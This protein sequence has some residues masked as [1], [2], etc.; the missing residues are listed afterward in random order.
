MNIKKYR[1]KSIKE[2]IEMVKQDLGPD[3]VILATNRIEDTEEIEMLAATDLPGVKADTNVSLP[4]EQAGGKNISVNGQDNSNGTSRSMPNG[5][6]AGGDYAFNTDTPSKFAGFSPDS[7][8]N[9]KNVPDSG[10]LSNV[11]S[12]LSELKNQIHSFGKQVSDLSSLIQCSEA[13]NFPPLFNK[14]VASGIQ[15]DTASIITNL[16]NSKLNL[17]PSMDKSTGTSSSE[18]SI[19]SLLSSL[20][21]SSPISLKPI[22]D[23]LSVEPASGKSNGKSASGGEKTSSPSQS[24]TKRNVPYLI[25]F[26]GPT[27][28]G[29]TTTIAKIASNFTIYDKLKVALITIDTYRLAAVEQLNTFAKIVDIPIEVVFSAMDFPN[30]LEKFKDMD[31][32]FIDTAGSSQKNEKYISE[33]CTFFNLIKPDEIHL[34][35]SL[36]TKTK[37][38]AD[39]IKNYDVLCP[40]KLVFTKLDETSSFGTLLESPFLSKKPISYLTTGQSIPDDIERANSSKIISHI[41]ELKERWEK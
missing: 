20:I 4:N 7:R 23:Y 17:L 34:V 21:S 5:R 39:I 18:E 8:Q 31:V 40:G 1:A 41:W 9:G 33:L 11:E 28:T 3:A 14:L 26:I 22:L 6:Q 36:T 15:A 30:S 16:I 38:I 24:V 27:G 12:Q 2:G 32:I 10:Q 37:D 25:A 13:V 35:I 19:K 29:K